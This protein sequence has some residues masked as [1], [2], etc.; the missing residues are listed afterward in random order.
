MQFIKPIAGDCTLLNLGLS[1]EDRKELTQNVNIVIHSA[2]TVRFNE[3]L[4]SATQIN[5][6]ATMDMLE[7]AKDM[8][9]LEVSK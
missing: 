9:Y 8:K 4:S 2:A 7:L 6:E 1:T 3:S 5:V